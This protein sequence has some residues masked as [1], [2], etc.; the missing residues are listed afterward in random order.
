[1][2]RIDGG[3]G[4]HIYVGDSYCLPY[5]LSPARFRFLKIMSRSC[6]REWGNG[7]KMLFSLFTFTKFCWYIGQKKI[8][9]CF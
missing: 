9:K 1:M 8:M 5:D 2:T 7:S 6:T 3:L 4:I